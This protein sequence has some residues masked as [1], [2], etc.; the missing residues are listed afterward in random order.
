LKF[1]TAKENSKKKLLIQNSK[2]FKNLVPALEPVVAR[3]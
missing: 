3:H 1:F 2:K